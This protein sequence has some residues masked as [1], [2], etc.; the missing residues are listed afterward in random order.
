MFHRDERGITLAELLATIA[1][2]SFI[3]LIITA[4]LLI[5]QRQ[6]TDQSEAAQHVTDV[7]IALKTITKDIRSYDVDFEQSEAN[8]IKFM[9][10]N[11]YYWDESKQVL[12]KDGADYVHEVKRF[13]VTYDDVE[14]IIAIEIESISGKKVETELTIRTKREGGSP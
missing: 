5:V 3:I 7:T 8:Y 10:G 4:V 9:N 1:I 14:K 2:G 11:Y 12:Q 6:Y 13:H